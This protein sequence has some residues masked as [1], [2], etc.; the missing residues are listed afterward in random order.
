MVVD[1]EGCLARVFGFL[2]EVL[3]AGTGLGILR[4]FGR[5]K[6]GLSGVDEVLAYVLGALT[7]AAIGFAAYLLLA[8]YPPPPRLPASGSGARVG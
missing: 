5:G 3:I 4:L 8:D 2:V 1:D 7:W 6:E